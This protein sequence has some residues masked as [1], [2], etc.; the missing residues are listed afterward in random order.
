MPDADYF[1]QVAFAGRPLRSRFHLNYLQNRAFHHV[2]ATERDGLATEPRDRH[3]TGTCPVLDERMHQYYCLPIYFAD[4]SGNRPSSARTDASTLIRPFET[5]CIN[6]PEL[7][8]LP[9]FARGAATR[10][11]SQPDRRVSPKIR[12]RNTIRSQLSPRIPYQSCQSKRCC[13]EL[14][15]TNYMPTRQIIICLRIFHSRIWTLIV[16]RNCRRTK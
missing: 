8:S 9:R 7:D 3:E 15:G 5:R 4:G 12:W 6:L 1:A 11:S 16:C 13:T 2:N 14:I 10:R